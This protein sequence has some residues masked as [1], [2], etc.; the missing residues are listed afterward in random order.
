M[1]IKKLGKNK[2]AVSLMISYVLL[3]VIAIV[4]SIIV[5]SYLRYVANVE[6][7][8]DCDEG[9]SLVVEDYMC[10][11]ADGKI[12]LV[13]RNN[14]RFNIEGFIPTFGGNLQREPATKLIFGSQPT[15][16]SVNPAV[17]SAPPMDPPRFFTPLKP[18]EIVNV[19]FTNTEKKS[20]GL[21]EIVSFSFLRNLKIQPYVIDEESGF[22]I[23][24][25]NV[26]IRQDVEDCQI[27]PFA[28]LLRPISEYTLPP[29]IPAESDPGFVQALEEYLEETG[30][31]VLVPTP[32][33]HYEFENNL[34]DTMN[35]AHIQQSLPTI[36]LQK[37]TDGRVGKAINFD[38]TYSLRTRRQEINNDLSRSELTLSFWLKKESDTGIILRKGIPGGFD[39]QLIDSKINTRVAQRGTE[40]S[41]ACEIQLSN[42]WT[43]VVLTALKE[44]KQRIYINGEFC[45]E[46]DVGTKK[47]N[48]LPKNLF[49]GNPGV[50]LQMDEIKFWKQELNSEEVAS[51]YAGY[52]NN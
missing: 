43:N 39:V 17:L 38:G 3:V 28:S 40:T 22:S 37:Y 42:Q 7:V 24:C 21:P 45:A 1:E 30:V 15:L 44:D 29:S 23:P 51:L 33:V 50:T 12:T 5:F 16:L 4:M 52:V 27:K 11:A 26:I 2:K 48:K 36:N 47:F 31:T 18:G 20:T 19:D 41:L 8:I 35:H 14:G 9:T 46:G 32:S 6:P 25:G 13:L 49:I 34:Q 10:D